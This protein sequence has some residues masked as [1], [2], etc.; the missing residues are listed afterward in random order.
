MNEPP[1][2][3]VRVAEE[4][5]SCVHIL[6]VTAAGSRVCRTQVTS[7]LRRQLVLFILRLLE[8][9]LSLCQIVHIFYLFIPF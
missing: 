7:T 6:R 3:C 8:P 2:L 1:A 9:L 4:V 5:E